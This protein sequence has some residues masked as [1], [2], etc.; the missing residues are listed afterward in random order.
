MT[1]DRNLH[2][3]TLAVVVA[4]SAGNTYHKPA[5]VGVRPSCGV[6]PSGSFVGKILHTIQSHYEPCSRCWTPEEIEA[7][8]AAAELEAPTP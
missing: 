5:G 4:T 7:I 1:F 6:A 2:P 8:E 3:E